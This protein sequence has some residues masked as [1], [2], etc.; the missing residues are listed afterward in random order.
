M[1]GSD[2]AEESINE[3]CGKGLKFGLE[4]SVWK[5]LVQVLAVSQVCYPT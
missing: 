3:V 1:S 2:S 5:P 4:V